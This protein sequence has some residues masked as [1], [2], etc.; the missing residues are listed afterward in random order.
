MPKL[1]D[2]AHLFNALDPKLGTKPKIQSLIYSAAPELD[3]MFFKI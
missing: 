3:G 2:L 1:D